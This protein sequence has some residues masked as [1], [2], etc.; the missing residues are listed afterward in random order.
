MHEW[1]GRIP[2]GRP[3]DAG[4]P[5]RREHAE[6]PTPSGRRTPERG[7]LAGMACAAKAARLMI[8]LIAATALIVGCGGDG[9][10]GQAPLSPMERCTQVLGHKPQGL[11]RTVATSGALVVATAGDYPPQSWVDDHGKLVGFDVEV[12]KRVGDLLGV[13]VNFITPEWDAVPAAL[14]GGKVQVSIGSL[15]PSEELEQALMFSTP[16]Y[17]MPARVAVKKG[18]PKLAGAS[19][20]AGK[21]V[22]VGAQTTY[23]YWLREHTQAVIKTYTAEADTFPELAAGR[24]DAVV[25][26][27]PT[28]AQAIRS[29]QPFVL[30]GKPLFS[31]EFAFAVRQG[32]TDLLALMEYAIRTLSDDGS[33]SRL[34]REWFG[35][36]DLSISAEN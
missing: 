31:Q 35:G 28:L 8:G 12:A 30:S 29:G 5:A 33:L 21:K 20:L 4:K 11:A 26:A 2:Q 27:G 24:L 15:A 16:Y 32:E 22:G 34:T 18:S 17:A 13:E 14:A 25:A 7:L 1:S 23:F 19:G 9:E 6:T 10:S 36:A 3:V